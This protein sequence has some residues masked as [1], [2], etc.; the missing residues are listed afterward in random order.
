MENNVELD[1]LTPVYYQKSSALR[2]RTSDLR[3]Y[4]RQKCI[5]EIKLCPQICIGIFLR[6]RAS[7]LGR[8]LR[9][10]YITEI[11]LCPQTC[12]GIFL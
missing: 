11:K 5:S 8:Y 12:S 2:I 6:I 4:S 9:Q 10:K 1:K 3:K 7:N